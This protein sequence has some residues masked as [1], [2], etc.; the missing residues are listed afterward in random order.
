[1]TV[2]GFLGVTVLVATGLSGGA[3]LRAPLAAQGPQASTA[4]LTG[5]VGSPA[6]ARMEG[7]LVSAR[8]QGS[9][10]TVTVVTNAEGVY[11]FPRARLE[12]GRYDV[13]IRAAGSCSRRRRPPC[14]WRWPKGPRR[15]WI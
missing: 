12:P 8:R 1:M 7:V 11:S 4:A 9:T 15:D 2:R 3:G 5:T 10:R 6:E 13:S 14:K